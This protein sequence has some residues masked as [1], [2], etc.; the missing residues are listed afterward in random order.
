MNAALSHLS[1]DIA[2]ATAGRF[3]FIF[4]V[5]LPRETLIYTPA[6]VHDSGFAKRSRY[7]LQLLTTIHQ[8]ILDVLPR[9]R[10]YAAHITSF[11]ASRH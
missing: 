2:I 11:H 7:G 4:E 8:P 5:L 3:G 9:F 1:C 6:F 10:V